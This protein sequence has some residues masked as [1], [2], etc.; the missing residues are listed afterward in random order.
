MNVPAVT[1]VH[2]V[3]AAGNGALAFAGHFRVAFVLF[4]GMLALQSSP[5]LDA[6]KIAYLV[7]TV[8]CLVGALAAVWNARRRPEVR[9]RAPW[10]AASAALAVLIAMSFFVA[11]SNG[12]S[13]TDWVRDVAAYALFAAVPVFALDGQASTS[14]KLLVGMLVLAGLLGGLSWAVEWLSRRQILELPF[15]RLVFPSGQLPGMLYLF[16]M[17]TALTAHRQ[18]A[19]WVMLA[20][21]ILGLFLLTGTRS[22]L[23]LL[24][25]P[26]AMAVLAGRVRIRSSLRSIASHGLV[27]VA[28]ILAFQLALALP[29]VLGLGRTTGE[30]GSSG[31]AAPSVPGVLGDRFGS[32]PAVLVNPASDASFKERVAQYEAAWALFVSSPIVGVGP[33]H[34]IDWVAVSGYPRTEFTADTPLVMPA[35]FGLLGILVFIAAAAAYGSTVRT[36]MRRDRRSVITLTLVGYGVWTIVGLPL[37]FPIEDKGAS[38]ALMLVLALAFAER[39]G[40]Q[41][42]DSAPFDELNAGV[43]ET[44]RPSR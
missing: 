3:G 40:P 16:A 30:P 22:S 19:A 6:T 37:G 23:L 29:V 20:G 44:Q 11:R 10:I 26:L 39:A 34:S 13:I 28:V 4:G 25:G 43:I 7:G 35:K 21:L 27:A 38:L 33:G 14:R 9:L 41:S 31:S 32:L 12:T 18:R 2:G 17:A 36:A 42:I 15:A 5:T 8:L 24:I 1:R